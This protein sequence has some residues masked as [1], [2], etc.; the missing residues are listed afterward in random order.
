MSEDKSAYVTLNL[1]KG[2]N[3]TEIKKAYV[4]MVRQYDPEQHTDMFMKIQDAYERLRDP[5]KRAHEDVFNYNYVS[6]DFNFTPEEKVEDGLPELNESI[7][8]MVEQVKAAPADPEKRVGLILQLMKRSYRHAMKKL[9]TEA[10]KDWVGVLQVDPT[11]QRAKNNLLFS[12]LYLGYYYAVHDLL[13]EAIDLWEKALRMDPDNVPLIHNLALATDRLPAP[14]KSQKYWAETVRRWKLLLDKTPDDEYQKNCIIEVHKHHGGR[15][16]SGAQTS[17]TKQEA[18]D[19][20]REIL[21]FDPSDF[22]AQFNIANALMEEAKFEEAID[23]LKKLALQHPKNL[24][25]VNLLGWAYLNA[26]KFEMAFTTWRRGLARDPNNH[27][28]RTSV[29]SAR[30]NVGKKLKEAGHFTQAL[31]HFKELLRIVPNE[32]EIH[33]ELGDTLLRRGDKRNALIEFQKVLEL[34]P[35]NKAARKAVSDIRMR[36]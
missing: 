19:Q 31:V 30:M 27:T 33:F 2:A 20:Y 28:I 36:A 24:E 16:L 6:G 13:E 21:K 11:H 35:K 34:D 7:V 17:E 4:E 32:W 5:V 3:E 8:K 14:E 12:Y 23:Q 22:D 1:R 15:A 25:I 9:W 29:I 18:I 26:G 10:I